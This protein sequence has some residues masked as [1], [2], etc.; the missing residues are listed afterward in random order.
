MNGEY[1]G[2]K[3]NILFPEVLR[4]DPPLGYAVAV[5]VVKLDDNTKGPDCSECLNSKNVRPAFLKE[6]QVWLTTTAML[7]LAQAAGIEF[8]EER[9]LDD[10]TD[11]RLCEIEVVTSRLSFDG[12]R[13]IQPFAKRI[14]YRNAEPKSPSG[15]QFIAE[16]ARTGARMRAITQIVG[17]SRIVWRTILARPFAVPCLVPAMEQ[18]ANHPE[19]GGHVT[20]M[21]AAR[22][23]NCENALYGAIAAARGG[24]VA[25]GFLPT[26]TP[27]K[28]L[29]PASYTP[30]AADTDYDAETGEVIEAP[31]PAPA[32]ATQPAPTPTPSDPADEAQRAAFLEWAREKWPKAADFYTFAQSILGHR[33]K[34]IRTISNDDRAK[35]RQAAEREDVPY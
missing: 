20:L 18:L 16:S 22:V 17:L 1:T 6:G 27:P 4:C 34:D 15:Q 30:L 23:M 21:L 14:D 35:I 10:G 5:R 31:A 9:H 7:K 8:T 24:L 12:H 28:M 25:G 11:Y 32:P 33:P 13:M 29:N 26:P 3:Y 19:V 2:D